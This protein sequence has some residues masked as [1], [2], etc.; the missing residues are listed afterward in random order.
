MRVRLS[1]EIALQ[2][3]PIQKTGKEKGQQLMAN[4]KE[5]GVHIKEQQTKV[6]LKQKGKCCEIKRVRKKFE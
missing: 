5:S 6:Q 1:T 4:E 2:I 3:T